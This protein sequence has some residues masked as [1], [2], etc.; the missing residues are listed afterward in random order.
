MNRDDL[1]E[2]ERRNYSQLETQKFPQSFSFPP[3]GEKSECDKEKHTD[4]NCWKE[5]QIFTVII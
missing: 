4:E 1:W 3:A 5:S 2:Q